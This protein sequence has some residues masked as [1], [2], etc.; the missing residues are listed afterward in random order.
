MVLFRFTKQT[1]NT[2]HFVQ[3][4]GYIVH[5]VLQALDSVVLNSNAGKMVK[6]FHY[7]FIHI[8]PQTHLK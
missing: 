3:E 4:S 8:P 7:G 6:V 2:S 5:C 1:C